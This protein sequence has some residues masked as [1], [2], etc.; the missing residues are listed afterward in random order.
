VPP[1]L[2]CPYQAILFPSFPCRPSISDLNMQQSASQA[3]LS[4]D[5]WDV[6]DEMD[7][8]EFVSSSIE[9]AELGLAEREESKLATEEEVP[10]HI[11]DT[12]GELMQD[13]QGA[14][15]SEDNDD[16][17]GGQTVSPGCSSG[18]KQVLDPVPHHAVFRGLSKLRVVWKKSNLKLSEKHDGRDVC[19]S[20]YISASM[21]LGVDSVTIGSVIHLPCSVEL[22]ATPNQRV[23]VLFVIRSKRGCTFAVFDEMNN[24]FSFVKPIDISTILEFLPNRKAVAR[25]RISAA[26]V[27]QERGPIVVDKVSI[28]RE[29]SGGWQ[30]AI[31]AFCEGM[32]DDNAS[33]EQRAKLETLKHSLLENIRPAK[34]AKPI[35]DTA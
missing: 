9:T 32:M 8:S 31:V 3:L 14:E 22:A 28:K 27:E 21:G 7:P 13:G 33:D 15:D 5:P 1:G 12:G 26:I 19:F 16:D 6:P 23:E 20:V 30:L 18:V 34:K 35:E 10:S 29:R 17:K 11:M 4:E 25:T 2:L 24:S